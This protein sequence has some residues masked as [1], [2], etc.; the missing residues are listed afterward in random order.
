MF[1]QNWKCFIIIIIEVLCVQHDVELEICTK[2][3]DTGDAA[4]QSEVIDGHTEFMKE[5]AVGQLSS[6]IPHPEP[7]HKSE[8]ECGESQG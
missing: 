7:R 1:F 5:T 8:E 2:H 6:W 4:I 3:Q